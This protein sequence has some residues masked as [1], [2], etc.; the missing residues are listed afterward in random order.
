MNTRNRVGLLMIGIILAACQVREVPPTTEP[1][2]C[3][4]ATGEPDYEAVIIDR[5]PGVVKPGQELQLSFQGGYYDIFPS[6][7]KIGNVRTYTYPT[8]EDLETRPREVEVFLNNALVHSQECAYECQ[9][10]FS[11]PEN[12]APGSHPLTIRPSSWLYTSRDMAFVLVVE[13]GD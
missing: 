12:L 8:I 3:I 10:G 6:C 4:A 2:P 9:I 13:P 11:L 7:E 5:P 1:E